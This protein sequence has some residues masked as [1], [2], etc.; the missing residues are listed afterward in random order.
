MKK[1]LFLFV[2]VFILCSC[3]HNVLV[4]ESIVNSSEKMVLNFTYKDEFYTSD[5]VMVNDTTAVFG[6]S[7]VGEFYNGLG[8][9]PEL[10]TVVNVDGSFSIYDNIKAME[11]AVKY[12]PT[13]KADNDLTINRLYVTIYED[14]KL[15]G[16]SANFE[17]SGAMSYN[18]NNL[19]SFYNDRGTYYTNFN[20][21][22]SSM[23]WSCDVV[24]YPWGGSRLVMGM[25][26]FY[27]DT[28]YEGKS[29]SFSE[30]TINKR[31]SEIHYFGSLPFP[32]GGN[33]GDRISSMKISY[34]G[35]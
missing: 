7:K 5:Y 4:D 35:H 19:N 11:D 33:W 6:D 3:E 13:L 9:N 12:T 28:D 20:D 18:V 31:S 23:K 8:E 30:V 26:T 32:G 24:P 17:L 25:V 1:S 16:K 10:V 34:F 14:S 22:I 15:K 21:K 27:Q 29:L 2:S